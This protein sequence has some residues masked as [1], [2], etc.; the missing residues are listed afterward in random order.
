MKKKTVVRTILVIVAVAALC[1]CAWCV[2]YLVQYYKGQS[3]GD[4][5]RKL[6]PES[7]VV[8]TPE[9]K[10]KVDIP[11]DFASLQ[12]MN[13]DIYAWVEIP[14]TDVSYAVLHREGDNPF[15]M[16]HSEDGSYFSGGCIYSEDYNSEDFT[17]RMTV[18]YGHNLRS[19]RMFAYLNEFAD[20]SVF[21]QHRTINVYLPDKMLVYEIFAAYP[22]S[23]EHLLA[24]HDFDNRSD[25]NA[26]FADALATDSADAHFLEGVT[27]DYDKDHILTL[28]TCYRRDNHQRFLVQGRL[29]EEYEGK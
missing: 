6:G 28:S 10:E 20:P 16:T 21:E 23:R 17:D 2:W 13:P 19:G 22:H 12:A 15:Y 29:I 26:F 18:L 8:A 1:A 4:D 25:F 14:G 7:A 24:C 3:L 9:P 27:P 11:V 5:V